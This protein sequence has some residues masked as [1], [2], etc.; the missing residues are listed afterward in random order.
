[1]VFISPSFIEILS[2]YNICKFKEYN[3][4][5]IYV[6]YTLYIYIAVRLLST[7]IPLC[8]CHFFVVI[9]FMTYFLNNF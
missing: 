3:M 1:M 7:S 6:Q 9:T 2:T 5:I 8:N 4:M